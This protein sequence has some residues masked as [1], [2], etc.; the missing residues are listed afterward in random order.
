MIYIKSASNNPYFNTASEEYILE[1]FD[2][3]KSAA[4]NNTEDIFMLWQNVPCVYL[5]VNQNA[6]AEINLDYAMKNNIKVVRRLSGGGC[7]YQDMGNI[8]F[9]FFSNASEENI[10]NFE[11]YTKP[12]INALKDL[13]VDAGLKG[14]ND[15]LI[16]GMKFSG[17]AQCVYTA[18]KTQPG[19]KRILHHGTILF[20]ANISKLSQV[21]NADEEKI[22]SKGVKSVRSRVTNV[23]DYLPGNKK[24]TS[25]Q[26]KDYLENYIVS[27]NN[28]KIYNF[29]D[30]DIKNIQYLADNYYCTS[31]FIYGTNLIYSFRN[32]KY[33]DFGTVEICFNVQDFKLK[34][35]KIYGDFF[36]ESD[37]KELESFLNGLPHDIKVIKERLYNNFDKSEKNISRFIKG[38]DIENFSGLFA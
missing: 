32:K 31:K 23:I 16:D 24:M 33:F 27:E 14:R 4:G 18:K 38:C 19:K 20:D 5:G 29:C 21:L 2:K 3:F 34:D 13:G 15:L 37:I 8:N 11:R 30:E 35:V 10:L 7:V 36:G 6:Y 12:V 9:S 1:N 17:N 26:F 28:C 25:A 22:K